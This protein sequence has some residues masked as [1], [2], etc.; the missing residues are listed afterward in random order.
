MTHLSEGCIMTHNI[1][2]NVSF[3]SGGEV[4]N[5]NVTTESQFYQDGYAQMPT[6]VKHC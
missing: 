5:N 4:S 3:I 6:N 1:T 2:F